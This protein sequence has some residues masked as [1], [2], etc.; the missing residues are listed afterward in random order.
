[1]KKHMHADELGHCM[2]L[3]PNVLSNPRCVSLVYQCTMYVWCPI[4]VLLDIFFRQITINIK[5]CVVFVFGLP[6]L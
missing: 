2:C 5:V 6:D 1:M 4:Y 3:A